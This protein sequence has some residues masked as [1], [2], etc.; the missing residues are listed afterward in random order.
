MASQQTN[1]NSS[2]TEELFA[3]FNDEQR[4]AA[5]Q[6]KPVYDFSAP[7]MARNTKILGFTFIGV[8]LMLAITGIAL[9][10]YEYGFHSPRMKTM[11]ALFLGLAMLGVSLIVAG[12]LLFT[13]KKHPQRAPYLKWGMLIFCIVTGLL[14]FVVTGFAGE[15]VYTDLLQVIIVWYALSVFIKQGRVY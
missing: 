9:F 2:Y 8:G 1:A 10:W 12:A 5:Q 4:R 7:L 11:L 15:T 14:L 6:G 13:L 3:S